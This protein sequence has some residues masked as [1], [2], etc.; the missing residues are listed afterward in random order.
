MARRLQLGTP[1]SIF[2]DEYPPVPTVSINAI[3]PPRSF[4]QSGTADQRDQERP[5]QFAGFLSAQT[6]NPPAAAA[7]DKPPASAPPASS[8]PAQADAPSREAKNASSSAGNR[9]PSGIAGPSSGKAKGIASASSVATD[10]PTA[11]KA[12]IVPKTIVSA[13]AEPILP[14]T[15]SPTPPAHAPAAVVAIAQSVTDGSDAKTNDKATNGGHAAVQIAAIP[16]PSTQSSQPGPGAAVP[17]MTANPEAVAAVAPA[18]TVSAE[19][20]VNGPGDDPLAVR[21]DAP[22]KADGPPPTVLPPKTASIPPI[23][24]DATATP[25][26]ADASRKTATPNS[27]GAPTQPANAILPTGSATPT[28]ATA[29]SADLPASGTEQ[30]LTVANS[31]VNGPAAPASTGIESNDR[32]RDAIKLPDSTDNAGLALQTQTAS[33]PSAAAITNSTAP[34]PSNQSAAASVPIAEVAVT[35]AIQAQSGKNQFEIRLDPPELGRID[36]QLNVDSRGTVS[37]RLI[38]ERPDTLNLLVRDA[39]QLQRALQDA[40]LNTT[41]GMEFSLADRGFA[42]RNGFAQQNEFALPRANGGAAGDTVPIV[43]LQGYA[44]RSRNGGLDIIV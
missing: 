23:L 34:S 29:R 6:D 26:T 22:G 24:P 9:Q 3:A 10:R 12:K 27:G 30:S 17:A 15:A 41:G 1:D 35:I 5:S 7:K 31:S 4:A 39:P 11:T 42:N 18:P 16:D 36:V 14:A 32:P 13:S 33:G 38:I 28:T 20:N 8:P 21:G 40:G 19:I 25:V 37:S 44:A 43:A 2:F